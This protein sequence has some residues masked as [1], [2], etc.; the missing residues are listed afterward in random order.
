M[1]INF[2][3]A[4]RCISGSV[5]KGRC[6][7][8][9]VSSGITNLMS[10]YSK[11]IWSYITPRLHLCWSHY[12]MYLHT[13]VSFGLAGGCVQQ[14]GAQASHPAEA[15]WADKA[16]AWSCT[17]WQA[18]ELAGRG[19]LGGTE[20]SCCRRLSRAGTQLLL[21]QAVVWFPLR[22]AACSCCEDRSGVALPFR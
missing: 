17:V 13:W 7:W 14:Y 6:W 20:R 12:N 11:S 5:S 1:N 8:W 2:R 21:S 15:V 16:L 22:S 10:H 4:L 9:L 18:V 19:L 3:N